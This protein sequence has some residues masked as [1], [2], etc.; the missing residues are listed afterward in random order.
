MSALEWYA[1]WFVERFRWIE[2]VAFF[3]RLR[4]NHGRWDWIDAVWL[5]L[6]LGCTPIEA[7]H[8]VLVL[9]GSVTGGGGVGNDPMHAWHAFLGGDV[10][11]TVHYKHAV[12]PSYFLH[13]TQRFV[14]HEYDAVLLDLGANM[15][16]YGSADSL[17]ALIRRLRCLHHVSSVAVVNWPGVIRSNAS[18]VAT[19]RTGATLI[20]VP[21][22]PDF[23]STDNIH[24]NAL[25]HARI[26]ER[27]RKHLAGPLNDGHAPEHCAP[28]ES[29][30]CYPDAMHMPVV[31]D[32]TGEPH[33]WKLVD[34]SPTPERMH[35]YGWTSNVSGATL[36][37][38][39]PPSGTCGAVVTLAYLASRWTGPFRLDCAPGCE[40]TPVRTF[41]Q[42]RIHP[43]PVVTG[44][45]DCDL[46]GSTQ[47][48]CGGVLKITRDTAF[49]LLRER[50]MPCRADVTVL[51]NRR[52]RLDGLY[53]RQP[54]EEFAWYARFSPPSTPAQRWFGANALKTNC[55][56]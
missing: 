11:P 9:G 18:R 55:S 35:K 6:R 21:H 45:E 20:E 28:I 1:D 40:C 44:H 42:K 12:D 53:V 33:G 10:R 17:E 15:F 27:V 39:I 37:L 4:L 54:S 38:V 34:E 24:P 16:G 25:G 32:V 23:Y 56:F 50:E 47:N 49:S 22:G 8:D 7:M 2:W 14:D 46:P 5:L 26:A 30:A 36:S 51:T 29:E 3:S 13:C 43:F 52:V 31:R 41:H 48:N 19:L